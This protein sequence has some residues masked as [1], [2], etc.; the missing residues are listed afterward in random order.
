MNLHEDTGLNMA[1]K[2]MATR[3]KAPPELHGRIVAALTREDPLP[4]PPPRKRFW[5]SLQQQWAGIGLAFACGVVASLTVTMFHAA[6]SEED[7]LAQEIVAGHVRSLM[8][9]HLADVA[10]SDRH[11]VKPWFS[12]KLD[13]SPPVHDL[14]NEGFQLTG[15]RLDYLDQRP[16]AA[17]VYR[18]QQHTINL[19]VWPSGGAPSH[20]VKSLSRQGF[21]MTDWSDSG[22]QFRAVSDLNSGELLSFTQLLRQKLKL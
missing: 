18:R 2:T 21:N 14:A 9:A 13:F 15:G 11:T 22:M 8:A 12:G 10:S 6:P 7:R 17:L 5:A 20:E 16:V 3:H 1:I 19:F 4:A